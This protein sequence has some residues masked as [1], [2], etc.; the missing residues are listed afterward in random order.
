MESTANLGTKTKRLRELIELVAR[1]SEA[2][3][4]LLL[5]KLVGNLGIPE[6]SNLTE[7]ELWDR[8]KE[9]E[10]EYQD[11]IGEICGHIS[12]LHYEI[13]GERITPHEWM[14]EA[15]CDRLP[16]FDHK[17]GGE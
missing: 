4:T 2:Y 11:L 3:R 1:V 14:V 16:E 6:G 17:S 9:Q 8:V 7:E 12:N 10:W 5:A 13:N 15:M